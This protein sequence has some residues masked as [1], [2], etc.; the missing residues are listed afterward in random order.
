VQ[1]V[2]DG[3][4]AR[5]PSGRPDV[6]LQG[7]THTVKNSHSL[8]RK[9]AS[10]AARTGRPV[11]ALAPGVNDTVRYTLTLPHQHYVAA[12]VD[13]V[14][15]MR[16]HGFALTTAKNFRGG[17]RDPGLTLT[18]PDAATGR[19]FEVQL[20]TPDSW[21]ATVDTHPDY[22]MFRSEAL[23]AVEKEFYARRIAARFST[24]AVPDGVGSLSRHLVP[25]G[26][27]ARMTAPALRTLHDP[28]LGAGLS[29]GVLAGRSLAWSDDQ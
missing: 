24:V 4:A 11:P 5:V 12:A 17:A 26:H 25:T 15:G 9:L 28:R 27:P 3:V 19:P 1:A 7:L 8:S 16:A 6:R 2:A 14:A 10:D 21:R 22:E 13:T 23:D 29:T 20:H 18:F